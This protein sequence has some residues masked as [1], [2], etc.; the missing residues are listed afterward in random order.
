MPQSFIIPVLIFSIFDI[1]LIFGV[2]FWI[3][4]RKEARLEQV[5]EICLEHKWEWIE[6]PDRSLDFKITSSRHLH[7]SWSLENKKNARKKSSLHGGAFTWLCASIQLSGQ[8]IIIGPKT[9]T[10]QTLPFDFNN[11]LLKKLFTYILKIEE[12]DLEFADFIEIK[13]PQIQKQYLCLSSDSSKAQKILDSD[14]IKT[15]LSAWTESRP[16]VMFSTQGLKIS[17]NESKDLKSL[18]V[19]MVQL[20]E[21]LIDTLT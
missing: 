9:G 14:K 12:Q 6:N 19:N 2:I 10:G 4:K 8:I 17:C 20:G 18:L 11:P 21:A 5:R 13:D 15:I 16:M 3:K 1:L 7:H